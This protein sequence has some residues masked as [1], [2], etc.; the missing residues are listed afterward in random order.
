MLIAGLSSPSRRKRGRGWD[1]VRG[2]RSIPD[3]RHAARACPRASLTRLL[4]SAS[5]DTR[6]LPS[7]SA[8]KKQA[9]TPRRAPSTE[10]CYSIYANLS[11]LCTKHADA[12]LQR[13][14]KLRAAGEGLISGRQGLPK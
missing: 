2:V 8:D 12:I 11:I 13:V 6:L 14:T 9:G 7:A 4:P 10:L 3:C 5:A 1:T